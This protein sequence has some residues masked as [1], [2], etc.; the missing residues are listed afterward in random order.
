MNIVSKSILGSIVQ[1]ALLNDQDLIARHPDLN[2]TAVTSTVATLLR[3]EY[4]TQ[5]DSGRYLPT[6]SG[7]ENA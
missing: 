3:K 7:V 1:E 2:P 4:I 5:S 6:Q